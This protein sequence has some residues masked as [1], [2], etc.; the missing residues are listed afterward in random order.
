MTQDQ[1][2]FA[3]SILVLATLMALWLLRRA[4]LRRAR[5]WPA[6][7]GRVVAA[8]VTLKSAGAQLG[9]A[10]YF[11]ELKYSYKVQ[12]QTYLGKMRRRFMLKG[13]AETWVAGY[14]R[15]RLTVRYNP[16]KVCDSVLLEH[17][18]LPSESATTAS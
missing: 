6:A 13:R 1:L 16:A 15:N 8:N 17:D 10:A 12:G 3:G 9:S 2:T 4:K 11:A 14:V 18:H 7:D 5:N